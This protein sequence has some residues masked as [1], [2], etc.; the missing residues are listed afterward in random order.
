MIEEHEKMLSRFERFSKWQVL[1]AGVAVC[2]EYKGRLKMRISIADKGPL[3]VDGRQDN[4]RS[5]E[6]ESYPAA[7]FMVRDLEQT[8]TEI[9]KLVQANYFDKEIKVLTDFQTQTESVPK[10][11]HHDKKRKAVLEKSSRLNALD[12]YLD[13]SGLLRVGGRI[14]K[15]NLSDSLKTTVILPKTCHIT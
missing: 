13:V 2:M 8:E 1:K 14:K 11:R 10:D 3:A 6:C 7:S 15:A 12:Q 5:R 4:G 9:L